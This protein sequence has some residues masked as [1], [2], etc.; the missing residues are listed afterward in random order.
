MVRGVRAMSEQQLFPVPPEAAKRAL[1]DDK[2]YE[3]MSRRSVSD[4]DGFWGEIG[5][6]VDW[7]KPFSKVKD[8]DYTGDVH[9]RWYQDGTLNVSANCLDRH[10]ATRGDQTALIWEGDDPGESK[11]ITYKEAH[12]QVCRMANVLKALGSK[13]GA[14]IPISMRMIPEAAYAMLAGAHTGAIHSVV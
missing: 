6:R 7:I 14:R 11:H 3:E 10:L 2:K 9:I 12:E 5:Q 1:I 4:P 13:R 8:V